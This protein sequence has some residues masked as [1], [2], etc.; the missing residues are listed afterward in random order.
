MINLTRRVGFEVAL[1]VLPSR[2]VDDF[3]VFF[4]TRR[5]SKRR[6]Q[7]DTQERRKSIPSLRFGLRLH[8]LFLAFPAVGIRDD[9]AAVGGTGG[10]RVRICCGCGIGSGR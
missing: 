3:E 1:L 8:L 10:G 2:C 7:D 9:G 4:I 6:M 5:V